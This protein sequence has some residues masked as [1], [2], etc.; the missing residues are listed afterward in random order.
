MKN[1]DQKSSSEFCIQFFIYIN[2]IIVCHAV[3]FDY[4]ILLVDEFIFVWFIFID[5]KKINIS[6]LYQKQ[7]NRKSFRRWF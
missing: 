6:T 3:A 7:R 4:F 5:I 2:L 1:I